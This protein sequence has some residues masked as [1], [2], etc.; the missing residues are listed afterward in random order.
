MGRRAVIALGILLACCCSA[1]ALN[2]SLDINQYSHTAWTVRD[3]FFKS[4][5][6]AIAQTPDGYL[7]LGTDFGLLRFDGIR[8]VPWQPPAQQHL[9]SEYVSKLLCSRD[10][11]L[12][13]GTRG[14]L[15]SWKD[16]KLTL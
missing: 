11:A 8:A 9:P 15:A 6:H 3:G 12:W 13:I 4:N 14:G 10:G 5:I 7:W 2:P 1:A 16:G